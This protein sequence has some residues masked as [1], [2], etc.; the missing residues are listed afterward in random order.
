MAT[1]YYRLRDK[2]KYGTIVRAIGADNEE[3]VP[4]EGWKRSGIMIRYFCDESDYYDL[5]TEI[6]EK[7][8]LAAIAA[9]ENN[10]A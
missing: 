4:G 3:Y 2:E 10:V 8:A 5:Y 6:P 1:E 9:L 7:E